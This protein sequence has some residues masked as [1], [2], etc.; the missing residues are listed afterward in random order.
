MK[1]IT[2][3]PREFGVH[4]ECGIFGVV[5]K[6]KAPLPVRFTTDF[7]LFNTEGRNARV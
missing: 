1:S 6:E 2:I 5:Q 3:S 7:S 4:E